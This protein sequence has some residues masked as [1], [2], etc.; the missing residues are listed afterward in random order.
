[1]STENT[2]IAQTQNPIKAFFEAPSVKQKFQELLGRR[3]TQFVTSVLQIV[4]SNTHLQKANPQSIYMAAVTAAT[5]DLPINNNLAFAYIV[6]YKGEAQFQMAWRGF[7]QLAQRSGQYQRINVVDV[8]ENQFKS[9][10][11]LTEDLQ[12]DFTIDG[13]GVVVGYAA[14]FRLNNGFEKLVYWS[15]AKALAHGKKYSKSFAFGVWKDDPDAMARKTVLKNALSKWGILSVEMQ[16]AIVADQAVI[17]EDG[18]FK[19]VDNEAEPVDK[20]LERAYG[21]LGDCQTLEDIDML[22]STYPEMELEKVNERKYQ[23]NAS[24]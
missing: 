8:C 23:I 19:Y 3:S 21:L 13:N 16:T 24:K 1:M 20:E 12:A 4:S 5:L 2:A 22:C 15:K 6:P 17:T 18:Q 10:N 14:Y 11:E 9:Y 7:V